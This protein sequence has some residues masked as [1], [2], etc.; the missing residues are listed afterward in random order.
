MYAMCGDPEYRSAFESQR[1]ANREEILEE[2]RHLVGPVCVQAMIAEADSEARTYPIKEK[3]GPKDMPIENENGGNGPDM[4]S[5][6]NA[7]GDPVQTLSG[8]NINDFGAHMS[9]LSR[10]RTANCKSSVIS[11]R[12]VGW[13]SDDAFFG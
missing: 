2:S 10:I 13:S 4:K 7:G 12:Y 6:Q 3:C 11:T 5:H 1:S 9:K 8:M